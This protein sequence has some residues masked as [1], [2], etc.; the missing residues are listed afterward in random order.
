VTFFFLF[1]VARNYAKNKRPSSL[2]VPTD[3][4][5]SPVN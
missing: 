5:G 3:F 2:K 1:R 4:G